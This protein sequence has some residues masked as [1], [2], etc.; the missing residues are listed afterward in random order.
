MRG[1][2]AGAAVG[3]LVL[4]GCGG[5]QPGDARPSPSAAE[6]TSQAPVQGVEPTP[7]IAL[8]TVCDLLIDQSAMPH[9][10]ELEYIDARGESGEFWAG[11]HIEPA[12]WPAALEFGHAARD[13]L[14]LQFANE[15]A[16]GVAGHE[17]Y[18]TGPP[19]AD[20]LTD[21]RSDFLP[22]PPEGWPD[23]AAGL[24]G[25]EEG[26]WYEFVFVAELPQSWI[27]HRIQFF[28]PG[29]DGGD[30]EDYREPAYEAFTAYMDALAAEL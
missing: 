18:E 16:L 5:A 12:D 6:E 23:A 14:A 10:G 7:P 9:D 8:D 4:A 19:A 13:D 17:P 24:D 2:L 20:Y 21:A 27:E 29:S 26:H 30:L 28:V 3:L 22:V 11:C 15:A 1:L 25:L